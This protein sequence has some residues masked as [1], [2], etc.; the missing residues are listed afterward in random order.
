MLFF[1]IHYIASPCKKRSNVLT[2]NQILFTILLMKKNLFFIVFSVFL[3]INLTA[4]P[5][6]LNAGGGGLL[7]YTFTRYSL[8]GNAGSAEHIKSTQIMDRINYG[9]FLFFDAA[10]GEIAVSLR[11][12]RHSYEENVVTRSGNLNSTGTGTEMTL[13]FSLLGKYPFTVNEK[14]TWF[15]LLGVEYQA[16]LLEWRKP[17]G[18]IAH[19][20]TGG[21]LSADLDKNGKPYPL[22][23]WN[24]LTIDAGAG[25][26]YRIGERL[27]LRNELLFSFRLQTAYEAGALEMTKSQFSL[28]DIALKG[29]TGGP[30]LRTSLG[31]RVPEKK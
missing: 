27:F 8:E 1:S 29:L 16:A 11:G 14:I 5:L 10:Y 23:A 15:P 13:G 25:F 17:R 2:E 3:V 30:T 21:E 19:D 12:G 22:S 26:D 20:R 4:L 18:D 24:S 6:Q 31:Y 28:S 7:G 9:G